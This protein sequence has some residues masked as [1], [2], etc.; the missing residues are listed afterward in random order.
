[1]VSGL[2]SNSGRTENS[3]SGFGLVGSTP[4]DAYIKSLLDI[5]SESLID[6][7]R[8]DLTLK[9]RD[10]NSGTFQLKIHFGEGQPNTLGFKGGG[11]I[12]NLGG[13]YNV[14]VMPSGKDSVNVY[15]LKPATGPG[16][17][18]LVELN[19]NL[20][21]LLNT[22]NRLLTGNGGWS[23]TLNRK[24]PEEVSS[25]G[26]PSF[27]IIPDLSGDTASVLVYDGR[28]PC[29]EFASAY[30]LNLSP[31]CFKLK[32][33]LTLKRDPVTLSPT[34]Y[35]INRT[36]TRESLIQG[37]WTIIK[38]KISGKDVVIYQINPYN[39]E[40]SL[41]LLVGDNN[42]LFFLDKNLRLYVGNSDFSFTLNRI[43]PV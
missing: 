25:V 10:Y 28:T 38:K 11:V 40:T 5:S 3:I 16:K 9:I 2:C 8:W 35:S 36:G 26:L 29:R 32:W 31:D 13:E 1:M 39:P 30:N 6:F 43:V 23:Y 41:F 42:V 21:H 33:R 15:V 7:I 17:I 34:S 14:T 27:P 18:S 19:E 12:K 20:F 4:A 37:K 22:N 24:D